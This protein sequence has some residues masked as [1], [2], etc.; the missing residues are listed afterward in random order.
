MPWI[1]DTDR[2]IFREAAGVLRFTESELADIV[3]LA[4]K[5]HAIIVA[6]KGRER[7]NFRKVH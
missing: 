2:S 4:S 7:E 3:I 6:A 1:T 5:L